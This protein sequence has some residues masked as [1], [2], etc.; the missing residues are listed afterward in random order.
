LGTIGAD[1]PE[2]TGG[3]WNSGYSKIQSSVGGDSLAELCPI[4]DWSNGN[5]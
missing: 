4:I 5:L 3:S 1:I 2:V